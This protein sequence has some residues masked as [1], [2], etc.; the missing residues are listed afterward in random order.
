[1]LGTL[2]VHHCRWCCCTALRLCEHRQRCVN[3]SSAEHT[4]L[5]A[6]AALL[7]TA[8][9]LYCTT[10]PIAQHS[11]T[12]CEHT[13]VLLRH[14]CQHICYKSAQ[15]FLS[16]VVLLSIINHYSSTTEYHACLQ[17]CCIHSFLVHGSTA[18]LMAVCSMQALL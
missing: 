8:Q 7:L 11:T 16:A 3:V 5:G 1:M 2:L 17:V 12:C 9:L 6:V 15:R 18:A 14:R 10:G 13:Y 4:Y